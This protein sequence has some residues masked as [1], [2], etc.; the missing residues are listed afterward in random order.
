MAALQQRACTAD[1]SDEQARSR[2]PGPR[3][4]PGICAARHAHAITRRCSTYRL[5]WSSACGRWRLWSTVT[6][7][8]LDTVF[9]CPGVPE[10]FLASQNVL[11]MW[12]S[13]TCNPK[14]PPSTARDR[15]THPAP[16]VGGRAR[17][18]GARARAGHHRGGRRGARAA[19]RG[20]TALGARRSVCRAAPHT[21]AA[22]VV[23]HIRQAAGPLQSR[24]T[25]NL[26]R[27]EFAQPCVGPNVS[28]GE[29][30]LSAPFRSAA[31]PEAAGPC[32]GAR[33]QTPAPPR[34]PRLR[35]RTRAAATASSAA[36]SPSRRRPWLR[37]R[38]ASRACRSA[39][40][41]RW[42]PRPRVRRTRRTQT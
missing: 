5:G 28:P 42:R 19:A 14:Q 7:F 25:R 31:A 10:L 36:P 38:A 15:A 37:P 1:A 16:G 9:H 34:R 2:R 27:S 24:V 40:T 29:L 12:R 39:W 21:S 32:C 33:R 20:G 22:C 8:V 13:S 23:G 26:Q 17:G 11:E 3:P 18:R 35:P 6:A 4:A 41:P 30:F